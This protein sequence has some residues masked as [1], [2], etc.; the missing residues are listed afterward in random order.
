MPN[1]NRIGTSLNNGRPL[2]NYTPRIKNSY[3]RKGI[4]ERLNKYA[5]QNPEKY[6]MLMSR[7]SAKLLN[8]NNRLRKTQNA[9]I[10]ARVAERKLQAELNQ[11]A[12]LR[13]EARLLEEARLV[14]EAKLLEEARLLEESRLTKK[15][16]QTIQRSRNN[17]LN[18]NRRTCIN[19]VGCFPKSFFSS[20]FTKKSV[21][22]LL[23]DK[24]LQNK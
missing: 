12:R 13:E 7:A 3:A 19:G 15:K 10:L 22:H 16:S 4:G 20:F 17:S 9:I 8:K 21:N 18:R 5:E 23:I 6:K 2:R 1:Y 11:E 14:E 24:I